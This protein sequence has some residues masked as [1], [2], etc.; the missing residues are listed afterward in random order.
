MMRRVHS[1][2]QERLLGQYRV[3]MKRLPQF[4]KLGIEP[5]WIPGQGDVKGFCHD[6]VVRQYHDPRV[7]TDGGCRVAWMVQA[8]S[9]ARAHRSR[10]PDAQDIITLGEVVEPED[11]RDG[12][13]DVNVFVGN[14]KGAP[15]GLVHVFVD[16]LVRQLPVAPVQ[17]QVGFGPNRASHDTFP[18]DV[19]RVRTADDWYLAYE[20]V[21]PFR[22]GNGR[23]GK[24]LHNW[25][26][27]TLDEPVLV[28]DYFGG[29]NP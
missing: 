5:L 24:I 8:W 14:R 29:G 22:D 15:V 25:L 23:S 2:P 4:S 7:P 1:P 11:N 26:L 20:F 12:F 21:H 9:Y 16:M 17:M 27:G 3:E 13:R 18:H 19:H 10:N 28:R 6:E